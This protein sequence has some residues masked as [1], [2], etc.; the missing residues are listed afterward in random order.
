MNERMHEI[1]TPKIVTVCAVERPMRLPKNLVPNKPAI[2]APNN[3][4]SGIASKT[5]G[6]K[7]GV[8]I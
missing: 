6:F 8:V 3:G 5:R 1:A 4:A 2:A 7:I